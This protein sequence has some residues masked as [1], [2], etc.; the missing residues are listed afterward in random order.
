MADVTNAFQIGGAA[1]D[2]GWSGS[3]T[4]NA[5]AEYSMT[6]GVPY[7]YTF[8]DI[9]NLTFTVEFSEISGIPCYAANNWLFPSIDGAV[10]GGDRR[11]NSNEVI[12][13]KVSYSDPDGKLTNLR[14]AG[15]APYYNNNVWET[16]VFSTGGSSTSITASVNATVFDY[17][18]LGLSP[19]TMNNVDTWELLV[20]VD[21][22]LSDTLGGGTNFTESALGAFVLEY[23]VDTEYVVP[24][25]PLSNVFFD[26][27][28]N[29]IEFDNSIHG[30]TMTR[31]NNWGTAITLTTIDVIGQDGSSS[32]N[33]TNSVGNKTNNTENQLGVN[34]IDNIWGIGSEWRD[35][36]PNEAMVLTANVDMVMIAIDLGSQGPDTEMT[37]S[38][39]AFEDLVL[40]GE[41]NNGGGFSLSNTFVAAGS[42]I[43]F[44][45]T[46]TTNA[47]DWQLRIDDLTL[48]A[49]SDL[50]SYDAWVQAEGLT[51]AI[52]AYDDN[53]D[54]DDFDNLM[55]FALGG[56]PLVK[57]SD[58]IKPVY[59]DDDDGGSDYLNY[60]YRRRI[61]YELSEL[62]YEVGAGTDLLS[63]S[64]TQ[65]TEET[66]AGAIDAEYESVTNRISMDV[67]MQ[68]FM[69][70]EVTID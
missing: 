50:Q 55:E 41:G 49:F 16:T 6:F 53:W 56:D 22:S 17:E 14:L 57:D 62:T 12:R 26:F 24:Y 19:L 43:T 33:P 60:I 21:D 51:T 11:L 27:L 13:I 37:I 44:Q 10:D 48:Q 9:S 4:T 39:P 69:Q 61:Y 28:N 31:S 42:P 47:S 8:T 1:A 2:Y 30:A 46:S 58:A 54:N 40:F 67:E 66:G 23:T 5:P 45:M 25:T 3:W 36:N 52:D 15:I 20:S 68:Q 38:S 29:N 65:A 18:A 70:L 7:E 35:F 64:L 59:F 32:A 63:G 34:S